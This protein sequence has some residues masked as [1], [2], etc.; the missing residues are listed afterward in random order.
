[1]NDFEKFA[2]DEVCKA[3]EDIEVDI[4]PDVY[5]LSFYV[6]D[7][8]D[9]PRHPILQVGY[10]T[11]TR[12]SACTPAEGQTPGWP[13]AS[14]LHEAKWSFAFW[15][16]NELQL[17]GEPQTQGGLLLEELLK[18]K[19]LWYSDDDEHADFDRCTKSDTTTNK[20][21]KLWPEWKNSACST[22]STITRDCMLWVP[23]Q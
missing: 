16:Q 3:L 15:L 8:N 17:I 21:R 20:R 9:D 23:R 14:D 4:V 10:N 5:V 6:F 19:G 11:R 7:L 12:L 22:K 1:M 2:Y 18:S 13:I